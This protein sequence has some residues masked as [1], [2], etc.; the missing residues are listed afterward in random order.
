MKVSKSYGFLEFLHWTRRKLYVVIALAIVP[1][2][3]YQLLGQKWIALPWSMAVLLGT[4]TSF[5]VGFKNAQTYNRAVEAQQI[6]T[7]IASASRYW[8]TICRDFPTNPKSTKTLIARHLAW[9]TVLRY[10]LRERRV[11]ES[12]TSRANTEY[13]EKFYSIPETESPLEVELAKY[14]PEDELVRV[15]AMKNK[16]LWLIDAQSATLREL[17]AKQHLA[18]LHHTEMQKTLKDLL[19]QQSRAE[20]IKNFPYPRQYATIN[21]IFIWCFAALL[22]FC[23]INEFDL[24]SDGVSGFLAGRMVWLAIPFTALVSWMY[25]SLDQVG[26]STENPFEGAANDVPISYV[27]RLLEIELGEMLGE[28]DLPPLFHERH[29]IIL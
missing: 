2:V 5:I 11:W 20:R 23:V 8:G 14:L 3:L 13:R 21:K 6:W 25:V 15:I 16:G 28:T 27:S 1:V 18:V 29:E 9:L 24:L 4:A 26:E 7:A 17:F 12:V 19:D 10:Q 22:P